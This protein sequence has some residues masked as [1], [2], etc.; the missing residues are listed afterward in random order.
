M[1]FIFCEPFEPISLLIDAII[2]G[3][4]TSLQSGYCYCLRLQ[5]LAG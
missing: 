4:L 1:E 5:P 2:C 3:F